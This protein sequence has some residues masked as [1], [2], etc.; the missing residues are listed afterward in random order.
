MTI[1]ISVTVWTI[2]CFIALMLILDRLLFRPLLGFM[3]K[4][5]EKIEG[6]KQVRETALRQRQEEIL[7][8]EEE[9]AA[10]KKQAM[11]DGAAALEETKEEYARRT[12]GKKAEN[13][14]RIAALREELDRESGA[15][16]AAEEPRAD[17]LVAA[18][19]ERVQAW[20]SRA[21]ASRS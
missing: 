16:L 11:L 17:E 8:R 18:I 9:A 6:A 7:R 19:A 13:E 14:R 20:G 12:A 2:L 15:I 5:R 21:D 1:Q 4:R 3:D 10:A